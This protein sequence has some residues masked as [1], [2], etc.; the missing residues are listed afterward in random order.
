MPR[1]CVTA[2]LL[3]GL[4]CAWGVGLGLAAQEA[5]PS[6]PPPPPTTGDGD[7]NETAPSAED[8]ATPAPSALDWRQA[9][10]VL[11]ITAIVMAGLVGFEW[12]HRR[13]ML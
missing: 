8:Q 13:R 10:F 1:R 6:T 7:E 4:L 3:F 2:L 12:V 11:L 9:T 5:A